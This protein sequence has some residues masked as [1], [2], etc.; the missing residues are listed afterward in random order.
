MADK[1]GNKAGNLEKLKSLGFSVPAFISLEADCSES[2]FKAALKKHFEAS[3]LLAIRSS[4][5]V[6]DSIVKSYA[7]AFHTELAVPFQE[8]WNAFQKVKNS[9]PDG[10]NGIIIQEFI[11][12][13]YS[14]VCFV[15]LKL[16]QH[17]VNALPGLCRA[18][19]DGWES[20]HYEFRNAELQKQQFPQQGQCLLFNPGEGIVTQE[21]ER[22]DQMDLIQQVI[23]E[24][25]AVAEH[26]EEAQDI[27]WCVKDGML[28]FLQ[29]RPI[30]S[31]PW[32]EDDELMLFDS[33]NV[34]ES[35][36]GIIS[37]LTF[38]FARKLYK[39][40]YIDLLHHSGVPL[41]RLRKYESV[42]EHLVS[43]QYGRMYYRMD[44]WYRM[45][46]FLPGYESN[47]ENLEKMLSLNLSEHIDISEYRPS[48]SLK[49]TY[50]P[51]VA[52][53]FI[54]FSS[55]MLDLK[56]E[57]EQLI[58][59]L[60]DQK[61]QK[62]N[63][64][65]AIDKIQVLFDGVLR[66][67]YLTVE[68]DTVMMSLWAR[69]SK[70]KTKEEL[71]SILNFHSK[72]T[73]QIQAIVQLSRSLCAKPAIKS[74]LENKDQQQFEQSLFSHPEEK[75]ALDRYL[76]EYGGRFANEL[77]LE[78]QNIEED[79]DHFA[80]MIINFEGIEMPTSAGQ[81]SK[82]SYLVRMFKR[83]ASRRE[84][85]RL[86]RANMFALVRKLVLRVA[87]IYLEEGYIVKR[88]DIFYIDFDSLL[89]GEKPDPK[90]V[91]ENRS[92]ESHYR[93]MEAPSHF[94]VINGSWPKMDGNGLEKQIGA[95][96]GRFSGKALVIEE[97]EIPEKDSFDI[98]VT[99]RTDPGWTPILG[100]S[101]ALVVEHGGILSHASIVARELGI[102]AVIGVDQACRK[103]KTGDQLLVDA[104]KAEVH[105][106]K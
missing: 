106:L 7:G 1:H 36:A 51:R 20:E 40:V 10:Q 50:Y 16:D 75:A 65:E 23:R 83:F 90:L 12:S 2:E 48:T 6:E 26:F 53:K 13:D 27:E 77:K 30:S 44:N 95:S 42:F 57:A 35:Y 82:E 81:N 24:S 43:M 34:G 18:V 52:L 31:S 8:A 3:V 9:M 69:L 72:S 11:N 68:N 97:F 88:S 63:A 39:Q 15:D 71:N 22:K 38:S 92:L 5:A 19:V 78:T 73:E 87:D 33:A 59:D 102:P 55:R 89:A 58:S 62:L 76:N 79:F 4:A 99:K 17:I 93:Q 70:T 25:T 84:E 66:K 41:S 96:P 49:L 80:S 46:S 64:H 45:M 101:K 105:L 91:N 54:G 14:G 74:C 67:W 100:M 21:Y 94:K 86:L 60:N 32:K 98:L 37:P 103:F 56:H 29:S 104:D 47:K 85:F 28:Y 61:I